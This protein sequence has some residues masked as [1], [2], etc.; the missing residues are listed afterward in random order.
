MSVGT[1]WSPSVVVQKS[2]IDSMSATTAQSTESFA[3][4]LSSQACS[5][6]L[7]S[8]CSPWPRL[9]R[10]PSAAP[11]SPPPPPSSWMSTND[12]Q[13][14]EAEPAAADGDAP[15]P[16]EPTTAA[17]SVLDARRVEAAA[18]AI[19]HPRKTSWLGFG[20]REPDLDRAA[21]LRAHRR[22]VQGQVACLEPCIEPPCPP[23]L[24]LHRRAMPGS[25]TSSRAVSSAPNAA[26]Y[27][28]PVGRR[29][30]RRQPGLLVGRA[31][32][33]QPP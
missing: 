31:V 26:A 15:A 23:R 5:S 1:Y 18:L 9:P 10:P 13:P 21:H 24:G 19:P 22:H 25:A 30:D 6:W 29:P 17:A 28:V 12:D 20:H 27:A 16:A 32:G 14:D 33:S 8:A 2:W 4:P 7:L 11:T 3:S